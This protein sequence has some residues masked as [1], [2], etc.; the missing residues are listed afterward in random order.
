MHHTHWSAELASSQSTQL[1]IMGL[2]DD[3]LES[4]MTMCNVIQR[5]PSTLHINQA[6][7]L[8]PVASQQGALVLLC[9]THIASTLGYFRHFYCRQ[10]YLSHLQTE[11][12]YVTYQSKVW[13]HFPIWLIGKVCPNLTST[14]CKVFINIL[15]NKTLKYSTDQIQLSSQ[16][17]YFS[18][19]FSVVDNLI[20]KI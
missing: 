3:D 10:F 12:M 16:S 14:L 13:I 9:N 19:W 17:W 18:S 6:L 20:R 5:L 1:R 15:D 7:L 8:S 2:S 4:S 11:N